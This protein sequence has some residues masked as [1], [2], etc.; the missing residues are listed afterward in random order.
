M[1]CKPKNYDFA[2]AENNSTNFIQIRIIY[3]KYS[4]IGKKKKVVDLK[5]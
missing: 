4:E 3:R 2:A 5:S 1:C